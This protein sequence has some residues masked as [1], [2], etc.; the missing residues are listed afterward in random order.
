MERAIGAQ[1]TGICCCATAPA[2]W[3][4]VK[5]VAADYTSARLVVLPAY[6]IH[7]WYVEGL[8]DNWP[9][10]LEYYLDQNVCAPVGEIGV[11]GIRKSISR[12]LQRRVL[13]IQLELAVRLGRPVVLHGARA[14]GDL[15]ECVQPFASRLPAVIV[16]GFSSSS[17]IMRR[18]VAMGAYLS[19]AG[20]VCNPKA[21]TVRGAAVQVPIG[22]L[23]I[24]TDAPDLFPTGGTPAAMDENNRPINQPSNLKLIC[25]EIAELRHIA[26]D[27]IA[28]IT[29]SNARAA[30]LS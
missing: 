12:E 7:P 28:D 16:H 24:E 21:A 5:A 23:M 6:G 13:T 25:D 27:V 14:W 19:F 17:E 9:E 22:Q 26:S 3:Q 4:A 1:V 2:D 15:V 29:A 30:F 11:D 20:S 10:L 18:F 8:P